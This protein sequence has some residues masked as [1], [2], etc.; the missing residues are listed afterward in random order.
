MNFVSIGCSSLPLSGCVSDIMG[1]C[2]LKNGDLNE[3]SGGFLR[4]GL[5]KAVCSDSYKFPNQLCCS[6]IQ[7]KE[8]HKSSFY[9]LKEVE[10]GG[11]EFYSLMP[12][13]SY[14]KKGTEVETQHGEEFVDIK[15]GDII[16]LLDLIF[17]ENRDYVIKYNEQQVKAG[18]YGTRGYPFTDER[19]KFL[20]SEDDAAVKKPSLELLLGSPDRNYLISNK[21]DRVPIHTLKEKMAFSGLKTGYLN[22]F[23]GGFLRRGYIPSVKAACS[24]SYKFGKQFCSLAVQRKECHK[25]S[26]YEVREVGIGGS[27]F[28]PL[29]PRM[30]CAKK[31]MEVETQHDEEFDIKEGDIVNLSDLIFDENRDYLV[32]YN[33]QQDF[34]K[35]DS[36]S[37]S[38]MKRH[39]AKCLKAHGQLLQPQL[40]FQ[41]G[42]GDEVHL[43]AFKY[44]HAVMREKVSHYVMVNE[45]PFLHVESFMW[46][47]IM[48]TAT[49]F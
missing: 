10:K 36:S 5:V 6:A 1:F 48:R 38:S 21:G 42:P 3:F 46:N 40:Q 32:K 9:K 11:Y 44:D 20:K 4:R 2:G 7:R 37:T 16:N 25:S 31:G 30:S 34:M 23:S 45:L 18:Q 22:E 29:V 14:A 24:G 8:N 15:E 47:E 17:D 35:S 33:E 41:Q 12:R 28:Y 13:T 26:F 27:A 49:P 43:S 39:L 19:I